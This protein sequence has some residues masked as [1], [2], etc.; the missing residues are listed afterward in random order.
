MVRD[1]TIGYVGAAALAGVLTVVGTWLPWI[2]KIPGPDGAVTTEWVAGLDAGIGNGA[3]VDWL[4]V[5]L[6]AI[7]VGATALSRYDRRR[8]DP[9]LAVVGGFV[10][11]VSGGFL[12]SYAGA[13][14]IEPGLVVLFGGGLLFFVLGA[15]GF[16]VHYAV[17]LRIER[18][19]PDRRTE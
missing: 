18:E 10:L 2:S 16:L 19:G 5:S 17:D 13:Y 4:F 15:G 11:F 12:D 7:A 14:R 6:A 1:P 8:P 3:G 9:L